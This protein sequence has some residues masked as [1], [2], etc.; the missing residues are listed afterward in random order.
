MSSYISLWQRQYSGINNNMAVGCRHAY[1]YCTRKKKYNIHSFDVV[2][3]ISVMFRMIKTMVFFASFF[4]KTNFNVTCPFT[5]LS[6]TLFHRPVIQ[7]LIPRPLCVLR[8]RPSII[9]QMITPNNDASAA[10]HS[11]IKSIPFLAVQHFPQHA[12][13]WQSLVSS[14]T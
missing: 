10:P 5:P 3:S 14:L 7:P 13:L 1:H 8:V 6:H 9:F 2:T 12:A 4:S 11:A